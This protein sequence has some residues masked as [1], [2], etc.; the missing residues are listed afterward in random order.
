MKS[1]AISSD[2][3]ETWV[4]VCEE[5]RVAELYLERPG[6][7]SLVGNIYKGKVETF[8]PGMEAAFVDIG[9][10]RN[11]FL[12]ATEVVEPDLKPRSRGQGRHLRAGK[13]VLVQVTRDAM[14]GKGPRLTTDLGLAGRYLVYMPLSKTTGA[15]KRLADGERNRLRA[16]LRELR[17][18]KGGL[19]ARTAAEGVDRSD[20]ER[21]LRLLQRQW[22]AVVRKAA[23][24]EA[25]A[26]VHQEMDLALRCVR[27]A[28]S[29]DFESVD[30][31][32]A[33]V[34]RRVRNYLRAVAPE[35]A[36]RVR[37]HKRLPRLF[38][39][40]HLD[41]EISRALQRRVPL[42]SGGYLVIEQTEAMTVIDVNTGRYVGG[43]ALEDTILRTNLEACR[44]VVRQL[45]LR[46]IGGIIVIDFIDMAS[47][48]N[49][50]A[51][52]ALLRAELERDRTKTYV[53]ELSPLGLVEM[54]RQ[55]VTL[56]LREMLTVSCERCEGEGRVLSAQSALALVRRRVRQLAASVTL[57]IL[58]VEVHPQ[59]VALLNEEQGTRLS[60]LEA[61][62]GRRLL[63]E[64]A[65]PAV[66]VDHVAL[67]PE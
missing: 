43:K 15:S 16:L 58:R 63:V 62:T 41:Q 29:A 48:T 25:P 37:L 11:G 34:F 26:L 38:E 12:S 57:P 36:E 14:G 4:A 22:G 32:D 7:R 30:V 55:N 44:E 13:T 56:G 31:D 50:E 1:M 61:E 51:V 46:D 64:P 65:S 67:L 45:R 54:T 49:R 27:D 52:L 2:G 8:L 3:A 19:I 20:L 28:L 9:L 24:L 5:G 23:R 53:V 6:Q 59:V 39:A 17:P 60:E 66:P 18:E 33:T 47:R 35:L 40:L 21:D 42:P 10:G